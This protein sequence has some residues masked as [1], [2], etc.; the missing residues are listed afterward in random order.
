[1]DKMHKVYFTDHKQQI[2]N[3][4]D[5]R[6]TEPLSKMKICLSNE[7]P[8][9]KRF[10]SI[11]LLWSLFTNQKEYRAGLFELTDWIE[12]SKKKVVVYLKIKTD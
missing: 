12:I 8:F 6:I 1:M 4:R 7:I 3:I 9:R 2:G 10:H 11:T 5:N